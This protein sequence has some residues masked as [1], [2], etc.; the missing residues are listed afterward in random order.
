VSRPFQAATKPDKLSGCFLPQGFSFTSTCRASEVTLFLSARP[1]GKESVCSY[2]EQV[3]ARGGGKET[4][5]RGGGMCPIVSCSIR[6]S[7]STPPRPSPVRCAVPA[8]AGQRGPVSG[9]PHK[10]RLPG[11]GVVR[12]GVRASAGVFLQGAMG[13]LRPFLQRWKARHDRWR[14]IGPVVYTG[15]AAAF[16]RL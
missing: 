3:G 15:N 9:V 1:T 8:P 2:E 13:G 14:A 7:T 5:G 6:F 4:Q 11:V 10:P 16:S 12:Q